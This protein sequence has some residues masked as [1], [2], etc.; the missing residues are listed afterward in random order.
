MTGCEEPNLS[1]LSYTCGVLNE[2]LRRQGRLDEL[3]SKVY[4]LPREGYRGCQRRADD[5]VIQALDPLAEVGAN[6]VRLQSSSAPR[7]EDEKEDAS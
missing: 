4:G 2:H 3:I 7:I 6:F 1:C 5:E